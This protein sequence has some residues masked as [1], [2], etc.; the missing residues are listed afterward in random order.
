MGTDYWASDTPIAFPAV[1]TAHHT[2]GIQTAQE[3]V[4]TTVHKETYLPK[5]PVCVFVLNTIRFTTIFFLP[6]FHVESQGM[7]SHM[8]SQWM[9]STNK[10]TINRFISAFQSMMGRVT[11]YTSITMLQILYSTDD[12]SKTKTCASAN[13]NFKTDFRKLHL[14]L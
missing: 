10:S 12:T 9:F 14:C 3:V 6:K 11:C 8:K 4:I 13:S 5:E 7:P 2:R 1:G